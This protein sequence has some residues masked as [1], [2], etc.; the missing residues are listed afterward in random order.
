MHKHCQSVA[1]PL[2]DPPG[3]PMCKAVDL[4]RAPGGNAIERARSSAAEPA[5]S[6][7]RAR[8][9]AAE[10]AG[11]AERARSSAAERARS[12][13]TAVLK[14]G[15]GAQQRAACT[16]DSQPSRVCPAAPTFRDS[17]RA[18]GKDGP[19][20]QC[21][22]CDAGPLV[23]ARNRTAGSAWATRGC[24]FSA[25]SPL[26]DYLDQLVA[27][28]RESHGSRCESVAY[29]VAFGAAYVHHRPSRSF[30]DVNC[31][32]IFKLA[33]GAH[34]Q[35]G[36][37]VRPADNGWHAVEL[38]AA[39]LPYVA[40]EMRRNVKVF[41]MFGARFFPWAK[42]LFWI[43]SK[44]K[45]AM[46]SP[47]VFYDQFLAGRDR[48]CAA[49]IGLPQHRY[50]FGPTATHVPRQ[51]LNLRLHANTI[52][53][54]NRARN[55]TSSVDTL[56]AQISAYD[57]W[58]STAPP[59]AATASSMTLIDSAFF[60]MD[61]STQRCADFNLALGCVWFS[62]MACY[63]DRDQVS[64]PM[65]MARGLGLGPLEMDNGKLSPWMGPEETY[66]LGDK[67]NNPY[68]TIVAPT[69]Y[70]WYFVHKLVK[71]NR[72]PPAT[73]KAPSL[74]HRRAVRARADASES[75]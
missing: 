17:I 74:A 10:R 44:L 24:G 5:R 71:L 21:F 46:Q 64:F 20:R 62:E 1:S 49:F 22:F 4:G 48:P 42:Q 30:L 8:N 13:S 33:Q 38:D 39:L 65:A 31:S 2:P 56:R 54:G 27:L 15:G 63:S 68:A 35:R 12:K 41:K 73:Q 26:T 28:L 18:A 52:I 72:Q 51:S 60:A 61:L 66:V 6:A 25:G 23:P 19:R 67:H 29:S 40:S 37:T 43:D 50:A 55:V 59:A 3:M 53:R 9:N 32:F 36:T 11:S 47:L 69:G 16:C 7:E 45:P 75:G 57:E 58:A 70:H 14:A 34:A